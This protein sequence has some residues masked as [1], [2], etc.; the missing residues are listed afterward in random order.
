MT[1]PPQNQAPSAP[2]Q[3]SE[4]VI[5]I[6]TRHPLAI[7]GTPAKRP[8]KHPAKRPAGQRSAPQPRFLKSARPVVTIY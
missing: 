6:V 8:A 1:P 7:T 2:A 5:N 3:P 4:D